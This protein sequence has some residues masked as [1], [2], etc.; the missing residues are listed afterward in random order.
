[1]FRPANAISKTLVWVAVLFTPLQGFSSQRCCC[2]DGIQVGKHHCQ[3]ESAGNC[4]C[5]SSQAIQERSD[6]GASCCHSG[7]SRATCDGCGCQCGCC[8]KNEPEPAQPSQKRSSENRDRGC[9]QVAESP[10]CG[11]IHTSD[12][13][14]QPTLDRFIADDTA[15][16]RCVFLCRFRL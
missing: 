9:D 12:E 14:Q 2:G 6:G 7:L 11:V 4:C 1:M 3:S 5:C 13:R 16:E 8:S 10:L 15:A